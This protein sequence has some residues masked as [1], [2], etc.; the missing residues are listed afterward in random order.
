MTAQRKDSMRVTPSPGEQSERL[1]RTAQEIDERIETIYDRQFTRF[2]DTLNAKLEPVLGG[3]K[4]AI[5]AA[6]QASEKVNGI[7]W[8]VTGDPKNNIQG[9]LPQIQESLAGVKEDIQDLKEQEIKQDQRQAKIEEQRAQDNAQHTR[10]YKR[11]KRQ[12]TEA[13]ENQGAIRAG[14]SRINEFMSEETGKDGESRYVKLGKL[15]AKGLVALLVSFGAGYSSQSHPIRYSLW[16]IG[17]IIRG[18]K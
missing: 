17:Q 8:L 11:L 3:T 16:R 12:M 15:T 1:W 9:V 6:Q 14:V 13:I 18:A 10:Q 2:M 7:M 4:E 5:H